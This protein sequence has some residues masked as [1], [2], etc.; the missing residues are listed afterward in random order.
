MPSAQRIVTENKLDAAAIAGTGKDGRDHQ[1]RRPGRPGSP[2]QAPRRAAAPAAPRAIHE[3]EERVKMTRL[4]QTIARRLKEA[5]NTAAM[6]TT[7]NE[8]DMTRSW[9]C[10]T[11]QGRLREDATA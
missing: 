7:F 2:R 11:V 1:G 5:Q 10:A 8:V 9:P 4:R 3:R 6:L